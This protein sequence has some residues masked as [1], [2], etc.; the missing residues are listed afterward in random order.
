MATKYKGILAGR[1]NLNYHTTNIHLWQDGPTYKTGGIAFTA[2]IIFCKHL[3][4]MYILLWKYSHI[5]FYPTQPFLQVTQISTVSIE[6]TTSFS[7]I[8]NEGSIRLYILKS[9]TKSGIKARKRGKKTSQEIIIRNRE[10]ILYR[11]MY[12]EIV[13]LAR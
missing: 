11:P 10:W 8:L 2:A 7:K 5:Y 9:N 6:L 4:K 3:T 1:L 12:N 13:F